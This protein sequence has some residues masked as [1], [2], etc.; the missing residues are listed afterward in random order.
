MDEIDPNR[1]FRTRPLLQ[2]LAV[3][4]PL[5]VAAL[6]FLV[7]SPQAFALAALRLTLLTDAPWRV[8]L[9]FRWWASNCRPSL[10]RKAQSLH[11]SCWSLKTTTFDCQLAAT[12]R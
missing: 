9:T 8:A 5:G 10:H 11:Q 1:V 3:A 6:V 12:E 2:K 4:G 7:L